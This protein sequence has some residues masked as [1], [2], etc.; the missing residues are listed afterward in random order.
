[1][2]EKNRRGGLDGDIAVGVCAFALSGRRIEQPSTTSC[3][4][5]TTAA[6]TDTRLVNVNRFQ[7]RQIEAEAESAAG[8]RYCEPLL[9]LASAG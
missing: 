5:A 2:A 1:M 6:A 7:G 9:G 3:E 8:P 4:G